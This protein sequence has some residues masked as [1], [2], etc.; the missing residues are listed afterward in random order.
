MNED[1]GKP[2]QTLIS[3]LERR[4]EREKTARRAAEAIAEE[5][6]RQLYQTNGQLTLLN[7]VAL[8]MMEEQAIE[9]TMQAVLG[10]IANYLNADIG[11]VCVTSVDLRYLFN[12][13][14]WFH[15][16]VHE[17]FSEFRSEVE[18]QFNINPIISPNM[19]EPIKAISFDEYFG[20]FFEAIQERYRLK[21]YISIPLVIVNEIPLVL[22][23]F[24]STGN[25]RPNDIDSLMR[26]IGGQISIQLERELIRRQRQTELI[27]DSLT[28]LTNRRFLQDTI[29]KILNSGNSDPAKSATIF[30]IGYD[31]FRHIND[32]FGHNIGDKIIQEGANRIKLFLENFPSSYMTTVGRL[33]GDEFALIIENVA[34]FQFIEQVMERLLLALSTPYESFEYPFKCTASGGL[35]HFNK[36]A[37]SSFQIFSDADTALQYAKQKGGSKLIVFSEDMR[38]KTYRRR[39]LAANVIRGLAQDEF[40]LHYQPL[41]AV[42]SRRLIGFEA[43][44]RWRN[45]DGTLLN[46]IEFLPIAD[47]SG[48]T[49]PI[50]Q[51]VLKTTLSAV[52]RWSEATTLHPDFKM[53]INISPNH[54][55]TKDFGQECLD[56]LESSQVHPDRICLE[57]IESTILENNPIVLKNFDLLRT[58]GIAIAIDDFGTGYSSLSYLQKYQP[59]IIKIDK[60]FIFNVARNSESQKIVSAIIE[61]ADKLGVSVIAEGV[62]NEDDFSFLTHLGCDF[63]QG[64]LFS[65]PVSELAASEMLIH[66][67]SQW[68]K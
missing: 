65:R 32:T 19:H 24:S 11:R 10:H 64:Y 49:I 43:L 25:T 48:L 40:I 38:Q 62:E 3:R 27:K 31:N 13:S 34:E 30:V 37:K 52:A 4:L 41:I 7:T 68:I 45:T 58:N 51:W 6:L 47:Q 42:A 66:Q 33:A 2:E 53:G 39:I 35:V 36:M 21:T 8:S 50:G 67:S 23:F 28:G 29:E 16:G 60:E 56:L 14:I 9:Q 1:D 15:S 63:A 5:G 22:E 57:I 46:P 61:L 17:L 54:F 44:I 26:Q 55:M 59:D 12:R 18:N 20:E